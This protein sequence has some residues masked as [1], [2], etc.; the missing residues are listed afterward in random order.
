M[1]CVQFP[2]GMI[3][4]HV[5]LLDNILTELIGVELGFSGKP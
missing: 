4:D 1:N 5:E 3:Y 2:L